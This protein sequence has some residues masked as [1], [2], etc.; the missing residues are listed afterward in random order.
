M[1]TETALHTARELF[2]AAVAAVDGQAVVRRALHIEDGRL[3]IP[4]ADVTHPLGHGRVI[5]VAIGK[6]AAAMAAAAEDVLGD[7]IAAGLA[8]TKHGRASQAPDG[9]H[10]IPVRE[11][12]HPTPDEDG[13]KAAAEMRALL[14]DLTE[15]DLVLCL[16][17]GGGSALLT[18]PA[19]PVTLDDLQAV[20]NALLEAGA[21][22]NELNAVRKHLETLKGGGLA[23][24]AAPAR[25][26]TLAISDVL[27]DP[28]DVIAS[29]PTVGDEST[30]ADA[31]G[32]I[33]QYGLAE[34]APESVQERLQA[35]QRGDE[36]ETPRPDDPLFGHVT[37]V[38][39][40]N[41]PR[42]AAAAARRAEEL[43]W[44][45]TVGDLTIEGEARDIGA[46]LAE[47]ARQQAGGGRRC[48]LGGGETTVTVRGDGL[49]GRNTE[50]ALAV[51]IALDGKPHI[52]IASLATDGDDGP[53]HTA[54][55][56][57]TGATAA[58]ARDLGLDPADYLA[59]NDSATFFK[60]VGG[61]LITG[62]TRTNVAD[63]YCVLRDE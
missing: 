14:D 30:F 28:L 43:G 19:D 12:G 55:A 59:R 38:V 24:V 20:T 16:L 54:G 6:A 32:V 47:Q 21:T 44:Q 15:D 57:A 52:A 23:Q 37:T 5:V 56:V 40:A 33:E 3:V 13:L 46:Q 51:A 31:W 22:I 8:I 41:L 10:R 35:G 29:G 53:T 2:T 42:A 50:V 63:L 48:W 60:R 9:H 62:P 18:A 1:D 39:I 49:G 7:H 17:S 11:A 4:D 34:Q 45:T 58:R 27:G 61:L 25:V 36:P 26:V